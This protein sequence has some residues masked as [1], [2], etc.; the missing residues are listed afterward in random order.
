MADLS[1]EQVVD[2]PTRLAVLGNTLVRTLVD[3]CYVTDPRSYSTPRVVSVGDSDH[4]GQIISQLALNSAKRPSTIKARVFRGFNPAGYLQDQVDAS[5]NHQ[6]IS[7]ISVE[8]ADGIYHSE[9]Q[10]AA[11]K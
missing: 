4:Q 11:N 7:Q 2:R 6:V 3:Q 10:Y 8:E 1:L 9:V 5:V